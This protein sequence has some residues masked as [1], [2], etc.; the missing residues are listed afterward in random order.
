MSQPSEDPDTVDLTL[1]F[2]GL[3]ML[4]L[5]VD[6]PITLWLSPLLSRLHLFLGHLFPIRHPPFVPKS[7]PL[8]QWRP[9]PAFKIPSNLCPRFGLLQ[10]SLIEQ[11]QLGKRVSGP[12]PSW[13]EG[14]RPQTRHPPLSSRIG[15]GVF[16]EPRDW[17][18]LRSSRP[19]LLSV[20]QLGL[21]R[22]VERFAT[23][24]LHRLKPRSILLGQHSNFQ[25][26][27]SR[28]KCSGR[29]GDDP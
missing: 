24:S 22:A 10:R 28:T 4:L 21:W 19:Q 23:P 15:P 3:S 13:T 12:E 14:C 7:A 27:S 17:L 29:V 9:E 11:S 2:A 1:D 8:S 5:S 16:C 18:C 6:L 25:D 20:R 26:D